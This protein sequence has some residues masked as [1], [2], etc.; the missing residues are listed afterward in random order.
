MTTKNT[1]GTASGF[2]DLINQII[3]WT[4]DLSVHGSDAW[5]LM[6][7]DTWP[8]GTILKAFGRKDGEYQYIGL[9]PDKV[10]AGT[11]YYKWLLTRKNIA[12]YFLW[13]KNTELPDQSLYFSDF[14]IRGNTVIVKT[15]T[16]TTHYYTF[17]EIPD[18]FVKSAQMLHFGVFKQYAA[19]LDWA[20]QAGGIDCS[21]I[22]LKPLT[23][24]HYSV[25]GS[26]VSETNRCNFYPPMYPG[27]G[28]PS[29][30]I[31]YDGPSA[32]YID[33]WLVKDRQRLII[34]MH[35]DGV[36]DSACIGQYEVYDH[37]EYAFPAVVVGGT[38]G[39]VNEISEVY[40][41]PHQRT[42]TLVSGVKLD[43]RPQQWS[44]SHGIAPYAASPI[45]E[46]NMST[47]VM[48]MLPDGTWQ[49]F[50]NYVQAIDTST[51]NRTVL[52]PVRPVNIP[53]RIRPCENSVIDFT[54]VYDTE[55]T[56]CMKLE[57]VEL[58]EIAQDRK[59][60][61]G[62]IP[63]MYFPS[64]PIRQYGEISIAGIKY[65]SLP[66]SW[67]DRKFHIPGV[68]KEYDPDKLLAEER[69]IDSLS[70]VMNLLI[71]LEE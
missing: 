68:V 47:Q 64:R 38:S 35:N 19:D 43:Y 36:W 51:V 53:Y 10:V 24:S 40:Y 23:P 29:F 44:L 42:P 22:V 1:K 14:T 2:D 45:D 27:C 48:A 37:N 17:D 3:T 12:T 41:S 6:R 55:S 11:T 50:S 13:N 56:S 67:E 9:M 65:I 62:K 52:E 31:A 8:R 28:Y 46:S 60:I 58:L 71:R 18:I 57:P 70:K 32:G 39:M 20:E 54:H 34:V 33:Y 66:N 25:T 49:A 61:L 5:T 59:G 7:H 15:K 4:T 16:G 26:Y 69:R 21:S 30:G 63:Y